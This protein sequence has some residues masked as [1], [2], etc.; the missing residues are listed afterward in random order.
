[1]DM[2]LR[3]QTKEALAE[4]II[5]KNCN[6]FAT[7]TFNEYEAGS[8]TEIGAEQRVRH[9]YNR[10]MRQL[11]GARWHKQKRGKQAFCLATLEYGTGK[12]KTAITGIHWH[13]LYRIRDD[14]IEKFDAIEH[15][16]IW[17]G[18]NGLHRY[19]DL[20]YLKTEQEL[21][22]AAH[23]AV[24]DTWMRDDGGYVLCGNGTI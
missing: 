24:K 2:K 17:Q 13:L 10:Q 1:M 23:Y 5:E 15:C 12:S 4:W 8:V 3:W 7:A 20:E 6:Y 21:R 18:M 14:L 9:F 11:L 22:K 19:F 16:N